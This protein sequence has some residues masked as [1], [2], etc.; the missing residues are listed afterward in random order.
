MNRMKTM[1]KL[2]LLP[3]LALSILPTSAQKRAG[4]WSVVPR[5]GITFSNVSSDGYLADADTRVK[6]GVMAGADVE[7]QATDML[8]LSLGAFFHRLGCRYANTELDG[9]QAGTYTAWENRR[10]H[11]DYLS[12]PL[13]AHF[14]LGKNILPGFSVNL[15]LQPQAKLNARYG[16]QQNEVTI[17]RDGSY[18]YSMGEDESVK[19]TQEKSFDLAIPVGISYE[20]QHVVIDLRYQRG[21]LKTYKDGLDGHNWAIVLCAGYRL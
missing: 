4:Q 17:G 20:R 21:L 8:S 1:N 15:G 11:I 16:Y 6:V 10:H 7:Y 14:G 19:S 2:F 9:T 13:M 5:L 18:T 12:I 3:L